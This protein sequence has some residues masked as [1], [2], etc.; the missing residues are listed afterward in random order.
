MNTRTYRL[1]GTPREQF[2]KYHALLLNDT[3]WV[4]KGG[5]YVG[6]DHGRRGDWLKRGEGWGY[7]VIDQ[8]IVPFRS[9]D[10]ILRRAEQ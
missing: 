3:L 6:L 9:L 8:V 7:I 2:P 10:I 4:C 5:L 1:S